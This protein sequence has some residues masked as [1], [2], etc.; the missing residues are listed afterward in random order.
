MTTTPNT[1]DAEPTETSPD[2]P[3]MESRPYVM[4]IDTY[5]VEDMHYLGGIDMGVPVIRFDQSEEVPT[6]QPLPPDIERPD[7]RYLWVENTERYPVVLGAT[8]YHGDSHAYSVRFYLG[9][10]GARQLARY[11]VAAAERE[12]CVRAWDGPGPW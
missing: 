10:S 1:D 3:T 4:R 8:G 12:D 6:S 5:D 2:E 9:I 11:L 7:F